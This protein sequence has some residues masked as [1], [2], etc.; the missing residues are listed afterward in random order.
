MTAEADRVRE[1]LTWLERSGTEKNRK[2][3]AWY[4]IVAD[5]VFG[6]SVSALQQLAKHL[7]RDHDLALAL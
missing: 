6:I 3:M 5:K 4:G 2:G 1:V 7:G